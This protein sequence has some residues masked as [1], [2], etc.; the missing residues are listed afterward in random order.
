MEICHYV[1]AKKEKKIYCFWL[2]CSIISLTMVTISLL[3][4]K[5]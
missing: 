3:T 4:Q 2:L 1:L 5:C